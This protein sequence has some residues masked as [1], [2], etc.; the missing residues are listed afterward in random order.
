MLCAMMSIDCCP[1]ARYSVRMSK[2][3]VAFYK[4]ASALEREVQK[5]KTQAFF[6]LPDSQQEVYPTKDIMRALKKTRSQIWRVRYA[7]K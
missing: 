2:T 4:K 6:A 1:S 5:L 7:K 3:A